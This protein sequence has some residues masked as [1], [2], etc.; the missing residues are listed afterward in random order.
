MT[1]ESLDFAGLRIEYD[2]RVLR[3]RPWTE[4][5]SRWAARLCAEAPAGRLLELCSGAGHI[6]L[7]A[8]ALSGRD[9]LCVDVHPAAVELTRRNAEAAGL[10][11]RVE[12]REAPLQEA[13]R[14]GEVFGL[15]VA[16]PPWVRST[17][18][19]G[20]AE[21]PPLAID[22]GADGLDLARACVEATH[23]HLAPG[24][25]LLLQ[26][27]DAVQAGQ[28]AGWA[29]QAGWAPVEL[30]EGDGGVVLHLRHP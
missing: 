1:V 26:L 27:G 20:F 10:G 25:A 2:D 16:D 9:L 12:V 21:D 28:V 11:D 4:L 3:P 17:E 14:P 29:E 30:R 5:Q 22:G 7:G 19:G 24:G 13:L 15:A 8:A 23:G 6:G 18:I